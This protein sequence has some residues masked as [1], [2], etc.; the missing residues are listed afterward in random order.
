MPAH[1]Y[2]KTTNN[3]IDYRSFPENDKIHQDKYL[4]IEIQ[5]ESV[6]MSYAT[7]TTGKKARSLGFSRKTSGI[8]PL[9]M[10]S[11]PE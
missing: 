1:N 7:V 8:S 11:V 5:Y 2:L 6:V 10:P 4:L 3:H 9:N